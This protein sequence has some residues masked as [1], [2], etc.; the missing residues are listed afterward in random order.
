MSFTVDLRAAKIP[1]L[2][3]IAVHYWFVITDRENVQRW[4]IWQSPNVSNTS[5]GHLHLNLMPSDRGV[6]NGN[7]W[8]EKQWQ[9][10][11][12]EKLAVIIRE[13]PADY[14]Y[15]YCYRYYPGPN[16]NTYVQWILNQAQIGYPL[17]HRGLGKH[18]LRYQQFL[19]N[20]KNVIGF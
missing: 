1:W 8:L 6:G 3:L 20:C 4:E 5:W 14:P 7:S 19:I 12:A 18:Y 11:K 2:G 9:G 15:N 16:S 10:I 13:T 17:S